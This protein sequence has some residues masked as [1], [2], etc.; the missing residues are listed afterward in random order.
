MKKNSLYYERSRLWLPYYDLALG[1]HASATIVNFGDAHKSGS[2]GFDTFV[3][4][5]KLTGGIAP[6]WKTM[7][8]DSAISMAELA[9]P[10]DLAREENWQSLAPILTLTTDEHIETP[11]NAYYYNDDTGDN[12]WTFI[13]W[14][15][16]LTV[17][18][19]KTLWCMFDAT[20]TDQRIWKSQMDDAQIESVLYDESANTY[21]GSKTNASPL[22]A[23]QLSMIA[24][25]Y[26]SA[27]GVDS[28]DT[29]LHFVNGAAASQAGN[30]S[31]VYVGMEA[32]ASNPE[33]MIGARD[34]ASAVD[35]YYS[36]EIL[37]GPW[38]PTWV[39]DDLSAATLLDYY[40]RM[41]L[42]LGI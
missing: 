11:Y 5:Q 16:P 10:M 29:L 42:G 6:T 28:G 4:L 31:G 9:T 25:T 34:G 20:G 12:P 14:I 27:G 17:S 36:G 3:G 13:M 23:G 2:V 41:R 24:L 15:R 39:N 32:L 30:N 37:G 26:D 7:K 19:F 18:G 22:A 21:E 40:E 38:G 1:L 35:A 33:I 8:A